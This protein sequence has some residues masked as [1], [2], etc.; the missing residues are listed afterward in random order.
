MAVKGL[1]GSIKI[2]IFRN[3][4]LFELQLLGNNLLFFLLWTLLCCLLIKIYTRIS[5]SRYIF[6]INIFSLNSKLI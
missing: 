3:L 5:R 6:C 4:R 2:Y 1:N